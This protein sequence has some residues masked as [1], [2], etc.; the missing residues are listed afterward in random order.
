M[1]PGSWDCWESL[2]F[3]SEPSLRRTPEPISTPRDISP[4]SS[5]RR[6]QSSACLLSFLSLFLSLL[7]Q[8]NPRFSYSG[9]SPVERLFQDSSQAPANHGP[10]LSLSLTDFF[11]SPRRCFSSVIE[12]G[13][14]KHFRLSCQQRDQNGLCQRHTP[15]VWC[16]QSR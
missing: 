10:L 9:H 14:V 13:R 1:F 6:S 11:F 16:R 3:L 7:S 8:S 2:G 12:A 4:F 15:D 5:A